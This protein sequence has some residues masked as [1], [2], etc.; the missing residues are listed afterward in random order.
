MTFYVKD[1]ATNQTVCWVIRSA[2]WALQNAAIH[3]VYYAFNKCSCFYL[4]VTKWVKEEMYQPVIGHTKQLRRKTFFHFTLERSGFMCKLQGKKKRKQI[5]SL[6]THF[7]GKVLTNCIYGRYWV[8][9]A[10]LKREW[11]ELYLTLKFNVNVH[12][13]LVFLINVYIYIDVN[14]VYAYMYFNFEN[15]CNNLL[16]VCAL[17]HVLSPEIVDLFQ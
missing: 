2:A 17:V 3:M 16:N 9:S 12:S 13:G 14:G 15:C 7:E 11:N 8:H 6:W 5:A 4:C 10:L 1:K